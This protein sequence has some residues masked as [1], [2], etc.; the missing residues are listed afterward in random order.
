MNVRTRYA[1]SPTGLQH[2]GVIRTAIFA[3]LLAQHS[4][5]QFL[6][7]I[8]DT[9]KAR[10]VEGSIDYLYESLRWL[11]LEW[12]EEPLKQSDR[13]DIYKKYAHALIDLG[14]AY[15]DPYTPTE[16]DS[17]RE[18]A[19]ADKKPFL[20][21][22]HRPSNPP[23]W[24]GSQPLRFRI[25]KLKTHS[26]RDAVRG[27]L[28]AGPE[29]LDDFILIKSDGYPTYNFAHII[30]DHDMEI[31]HVL[32]GEEFISSTPKFLSVYEALGW[33]P[34]VFATMPLVLGREGGRKLSKRDGSQ[35]I[36]EYRDQGYLP[37]ALLNF[38][39]S[40]GWNDGTEQEIYDREELIEK[41]RLDRIQRSPARFDIDRLISLNGHYIRQL[42]LDDLAIRAEQFWPE[43]A[44]THDDAY[45]KQVLAALQDRLKHL[46]ELPK[47]SRYFFTD[48]PINPELISGNKQLSSLSA[49]ERSDLLNQAKAE[50]EQSDFTIDDLQSRL[51]VLL[52]ATGQKPA[53]LF[54]LIRIAI[55]QSPSSPGLADTLAVLGKAKSLARIDNLLS[56]RQEPN[57]N[58]LL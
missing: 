48:L 19:K 3:W 46:G 32:R 41:F 52:E 13:L 36:L 31:T 18:Q 21:R 57:I 1:P 35:P 44:G 30:D 15:A 50:L 51:N 39:V 20:Y 9:D 34:P 2:P 10:E 56:A 47:L 33:Q 26:W 49:G 23:E 12:D 17:F 6:L 58:S 28:S 43:E 4:G 55:T 11:G 14:H 40:L 37:D 53:V 5:G 45:K 16:V 8:E 27:E 25:A 38:L 29:A 22:D 7:R 54:G 24:D 42:T